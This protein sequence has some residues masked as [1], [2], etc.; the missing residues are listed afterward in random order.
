MTEL[1][2]TDIQKPFERYLDEIG[3]FRLPDFFIDVSPQHLVAWCAF[4]EGQP[5]TW[6]AEIR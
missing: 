1:W 5:E 2:V 3:P 4:H 6:I